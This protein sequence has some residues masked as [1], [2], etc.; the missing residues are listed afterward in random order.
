MRYNIGMDNDGIDDYFSSQFNKG[1]VSENKTETDCFWC[2][3]AYD[4]IDHDTCP[5]CATDVNTKEITIIKEKQ[6]G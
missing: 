3:T 2:N 4:R 1:N 5:N 6:N